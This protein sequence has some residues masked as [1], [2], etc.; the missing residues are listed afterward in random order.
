MR[1]IAVNFPFYVLYNLDVW[2]LILAFACI[3]LLILKHLIRFVFLL[4]VSS[5]T[6][7]KLKRN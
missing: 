4:I 1:M 2:A 7:P 5:R 6:K 3:A